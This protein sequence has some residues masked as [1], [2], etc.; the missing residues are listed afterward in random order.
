MTNPMTTQELDALVEAFEDATK[1]W[2]YE[3]DQGTTRH[4]IELA[5]QDYTEAKAALTTAITALRGEVDTLRTERDG[6]LAALRFIKKE[7]QKNKPNAEVYKDFLADRAVGSGKH[8]AELARVSF[9]PADKARLDAIEIRQGIVPSLSHLTPEQLEKGI[10]DVINRTG[11]P[12]EHIIAREAA[13]RNARLA[14]NFARHQEH[15]AQAATE[16]SRGVHELPDGHLDVEQQ[17]SKRCYP[18]PRCRH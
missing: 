9:T 10:S 16:R 15:P 1:V 14:D 7:A 4:N 3:S 6:L 13:A 18:P 12:P 5:K 17:N 11:R 8:L 2:G